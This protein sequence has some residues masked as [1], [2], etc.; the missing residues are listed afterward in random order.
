MTLIFAH[1]GFS[2]SFPENTM[3]AFFE[4]EKEQADGIELDVHLT[5]DWEPVV[6]HDEKVDRTT[7][8]TGYVKE[9]TFKQLRMLN[10]AWHNKKIIRKEPIPSLR[11]VFEWL[12][13]NDLFCNVE[14]KTEKIPYEGIE[15]IVASLIR[16]YRLEKRIIVS[17]FNHQSIICHHRLAPE[18]EIAPLIRKRLPKPWIYAK[19]IRAK[20]FHPHHRYVTNEMIK[21]SMENGIAV[22]PYT[23][24]KEKEL[25]RLFEIGCSAVI[26]DEPGKAVQIRNQFFPS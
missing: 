18:I 5:K 9:F 11:E 7:N 3:R 21:A 26:T 16:E 2:A 12:A 17:S 19:S 13:T 14:L 25:R 20:G 23:V 15:Q 10:A 22:R 4:A 24:N 8:G 6:I 1:R